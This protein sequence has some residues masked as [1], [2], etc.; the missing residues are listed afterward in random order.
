MR[1]MNNSGSGPLNGNSDSG[2]WIIAS[3]IILACTLF[4]RFSD[5][6]T[7]A[8]DMGLYL[9]CGQLLLQGQKPYVDFF[10]TNPPLIM[11]LSTL[12]ALGQLT[13]GGDILVWFHICMLALTLFISGLLAGLL[14]TSALKKFFFP[15]L[16]C[17][18]L[19]SAMSMFDYGQREHIFF[20]LFLP[21]FFFSLLRKSDKKPGGKFH[22]PLSIITGITAGIGFCLK[23]QFLLFALFLEAWTAKNAGL[24]YGKF[25][26]R[27]EFISCVA[28][29]FV[30]VL[31]FILLPSD[32]KSGLFGELMPMMLKGFSVYDADRPFFLEGTWLPLT[33]FSLSAL[34]TACLNLKNKWLALP[35]LLMLISSYLLIL[36]QAKNWS[37]YGIPLLGFSILTVFVLLMDREENKKF[38]IISISIT[39]GSMLY[40]AGQL[41]WLDKVAKGMDFR[42]APVVRKFAQANDKVLYLDVTSCPWYAFAAHANIMPACR[43]LWL[44]PITITEHELTKKKNERMRPALLEREERVIKNILRD[45]EKNKPPLIVCRKD[46]AYKLPESFNLFLFLNEKGLGTLF[47]KY[48]L[49]QEDSDFVYLTRKN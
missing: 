18:S 43:Y 39:I 11:Y 25:F 17:L 28:T 33:L 6:R 29:G 15:A 13:A 16:L 4:Q 47:E 48:T 46:R 7:M 40:S 41:W 26:L 37:Y 35:F 45:A 38:R 34:V 20:L 23:P 42:F 8:G 31:H 5:F 2:R 32:I 12:P 21:Y 27:P 1:F 22:T 19:L 30:Y 10:D 24:S 3:L 49:Q 44:F 36:I 9:Q 14:W